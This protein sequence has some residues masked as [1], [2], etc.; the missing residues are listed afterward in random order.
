MFVTMTVTVIVSTPRFGK[1]VSVGVGMGTKVNAIVV[2]VAGV[3]DA[4]PF[5]Q[6]EDGNGQRL[7]RPPIVPECVNI[8][9]SKRA[10]FPTFGSVGRPNGAPNHGSGDTY[11]TF[12]RATHILKIQTLATIRRRRPIVAKTNTNTNTNTMVMTMTMTMGCSIDG[13]CR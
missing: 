3:L 7:R 8:S 6:S 11:P 5:G 12:G 10:T 9:W 1:D 4:D 13:C 2:V